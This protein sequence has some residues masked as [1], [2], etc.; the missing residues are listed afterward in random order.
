M[1]LANQHQVIGRRGNLVLA[2]SMEVWP[3]SLLSSAGAPLPTFW[4]RLR[5][6]NSQ[7]DNSPAA[8]AAG[9]R[10]RLI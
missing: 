7:I 8:A 4:P 10:S 3:A 5:Q 9:G 2:L 1:N 6:H